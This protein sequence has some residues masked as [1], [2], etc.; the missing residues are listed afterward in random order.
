MSAL[1]ICCV[2]MHSASLMIQLFTSSCHPRTCQWPRSVARPR[3]SLL[4]QRCK[5]RASGCNCLIGIFN[6]SMCDRRAIAPQCASLMVLCRSRMRRVPRTR[7]CYIS[8]VLFVLSRSHQQMH[9]RWH[10]TN[11][12]L[13]LRI[14]GIRMDTNVRWSTSPIC[15]V[16]TDRLIE[17]ASCVFDRPLFLRAC[18]VL[19]NSLIYPHRMTAVRCMNC[20]VRWMRSKVHRFCQPQSSHPF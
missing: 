13:F 1:K 9:Y 5:L 8:F 6:L 14:V 16:L 11:G 2:R 7:M 12:H 19:S 17:T 10:S 18:I 20:A 3:P 4:S 15:E